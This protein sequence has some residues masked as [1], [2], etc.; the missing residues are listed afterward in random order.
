MTN[1]RIVL[2]SLIGMS[3]LVFGCAEDPPT[4]PEP[5]TVEEESAI[6][7][8]S[9]TTR[10]VFVG[11]DSAGVVL[12]G[13]LS[14]TSTTHL[15]RCGPNET[16]LLSGTGN[17]TH[18]GK[19]EAELSHCY[20]ASTSEITDG[21]LTLT[22][23]TGGS[24]EGTYEGELKQKSGAFSVEVTIDGGWVQATKVDNEEGKATLSGTVHS[25]GT[26]EATLSGWL[27][28]HLRNDLVDR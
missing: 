11:R 27:L 6:D 26:F 23:R 21:E 13:H 28:Q 8:S 7:E 3:T 4:A 15:G 20:N 2:L 5:F 9:S 24:L 25:N 1:L 10:R 19:T 12:E 16:A 18:L 22:G 14:G 17:V